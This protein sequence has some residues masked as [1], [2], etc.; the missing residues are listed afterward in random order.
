LRRLRISSSRATIT[1]S[2]FDS[3]PSNR[4]ASSMSGSGIFNV[5]RIEPTSLSLSGTLQQL[6]PVLHDDQLLLCALAFD[7]EE[8]AIRA[9]VVVG[10]EPTVLFKSV[11]EAIE[12]VSTRA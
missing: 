8:P 7:H 12:E 10:N 5:V 2:V 6:G 3:N 11:R 9:D 1:V 4:R